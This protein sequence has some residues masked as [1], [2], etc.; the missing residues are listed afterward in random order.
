MKWPGK[1]LDFYTHV[2]YI[3]NCAEYVPR[4]SL[5]G[6]LIS[7]KATIGQRRKIPDLDAATVSHGFPPFI[8]PFS[9]VFSR[10]LGFSQKF[11]RKTFLPHQRPT[12]PFITPAA[13]HQIWRQ[14]VGPFA[15]RF[16]HRPTGRQRVFQQHLRF[17]HHVQGR[18]RLGSIH[19][20]KHRLGARCKR[21]AGGTCR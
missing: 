19:Q 5:F 20:C 3:E 14:R 21:L 16:Q 9:T 17:S 8:V 4:S 15:Q 2:H 7:M 1:S 10:F 13:E 11:D 6:N 18:R 12:R